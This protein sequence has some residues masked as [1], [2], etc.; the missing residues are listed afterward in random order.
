MGNTAHMRIAI[1]SVLLFVVFPDRSV[2]FFLKPQFDFFIRTMKRPTTTLTQESSNDKKARTTTGPFSA[3]DKSFAAPVRELTSEELSRLLSSGKD[4]MEQ[5]TNEMEARAKSNTP[6]TDDELETVIQSLQYLTPRSSSS[7]ASPL[8]SE[9]KSEV[10][11]HWINLRQV[12]EDIAHISHKDWT[13]TKTNAQKLLPFLIPDHQEEGE[14]FPGPLSAYR[15]RRILKEGNWQGAVEQ[16]Q[17]FSTDEAAETAPWAVLVTGVNGIRKTTSLYQPWFGVLL[18]EA[19]VYPSISDLKEKSIAMSC[20]PTG[21]NSFFRQLDHMISTLCNKEFALLYALT[22]KRLSSSNSDNSK[23]QPSPDD[24]R[25]YSNFKA[26]IFTRYRTLSE[27]LGVLLLEQAQKVPLNCLMETSGR[28][29]AM[30][31][32]VDHV[33]PPTVYRKLALHFVINDLRHA[34]DSVDRRMVHEIHTGLQAIRPTTETTNESN[35]APDITIE[36]GNVVD[37]NAGGPYGSEVLPGVQEASDLVWN[38]VLDGTA[39]VGDDWFKATI[40]INAYESEPWTAQA[41]KPDGSK[42]ILYTFEGR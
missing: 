28:D 5:R 18:E 3:C 8:P 27:L 1:I 36:I 41:V 19:L 13:V 9:V 14:S 42:G 7:D 16:R 33:F 11:D 21:R 15:Y 37:A 4:L 30:F 22:E 23:R 6:F 25:A 26:A 24:I 32:Y 29:V 39:G 40:Q 38:T 17:S 12:L 10:E 35:S 34:Q 31:R 2:S 20:L